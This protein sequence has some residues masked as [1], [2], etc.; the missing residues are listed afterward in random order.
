[1]GQTIRATVDIGA[2]ALLAELKRQTS[3]N[4][5]TQKRLEKTAAL[6]WA[7]TTVFLYIMLE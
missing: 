5:L 1:M 7:F 2:D 6:I 4:L 3:P